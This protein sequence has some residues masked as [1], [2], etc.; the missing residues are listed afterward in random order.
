M[1]NFNNGIFHIHT[2]KVIY[3]GSQKYRSVLGSL[4]MYYTKYFE[5]KNYPSGEEALNVAQA[6][7]DKQVKKV[8]KRGYG[9]AILIGRVGLRD[10]FCIEQ[11]M[12]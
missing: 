8:K 11:F 3:T 12:I 10:S 2:Y 7:Y 6:F 5:V 9:E 1:E 4:L